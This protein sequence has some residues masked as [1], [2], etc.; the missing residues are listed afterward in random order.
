MPISSIEA[1]LKDYFGVISG[2]LTSKVLFLPLYGLYVVNGMSY[3]VEW[4]LPWVH[5]K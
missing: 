1:S 4:Y 5:H 3:D 2:A